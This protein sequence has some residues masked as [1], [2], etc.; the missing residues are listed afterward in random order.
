MS[1][2]NPLIAER[3]EKLQA[4]RAEA[5]KNGSAAFPNDFRPRHHA[6]DLH[7]RYGQVP[8]EELE[9]QAVGVVVAGRLMLKR[10]MGKACFGTLQDGSFGEKHGR[11]QIYVTQDA[12]GAEALAPGDRVWLRH[13]KAG[14]LSE[15]VNEFALVDGDRIVDTMLTYRGEGKAFL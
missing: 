6:A 2:D 4:L 1:D 11:L 15:H 13:T 3:R 8:N 7:H 5:A 14:E 12:V 10:I 9:P